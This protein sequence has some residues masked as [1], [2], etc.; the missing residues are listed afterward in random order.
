M[1]PF[2]SVVVPTK[3]RRIFIPQ[4]VR[5]YR[6]QDYPLDRMELV[7]LDDGAEPV[8][9]LLAE[10]RGARYLRRPAVEPVG[11]KRNRLI[12]A[13]RGDIIVHM[14]DDDYYPPSRVS[15]AVR[16]LAGSQAGLAGS[17]RMQILFVMA[18]KIAEVGPYGPGH[19][20]CN[21]MAYTRRYLEHHRY[22]DTRA[23]GEEPA[24]TNNFTEP[25]EQ[26]DPRQTIL[27]ISHSSNTFDKGRIRS[28][29][30][31]EPLRAFVTCKRSL[32]FYRYQLP[33]LLAERAPA[34]LRLRS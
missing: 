7:V 22:D 25:M 26:L 4:L 15:H 21:T 19:A 17:S 28:R 31:A 9:D 29:P 23:S 13:A 6:Q 10:V 20:T 3:D 12:E 30:L 32:S 5:C 8:E 14:D 24:F 33:R 16:R 1:L 2:V 18:Q 11:L 34:P 27:C